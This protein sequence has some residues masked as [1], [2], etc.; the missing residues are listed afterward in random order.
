MKAIQYSQQGSFDHL[1]VVD[2]PKPQ[3]KSGD[4]LVRVTAATVTPMDAKLLLGHL[5]FPIPMPHIPGNGGAGYIED[6]GDTAFQVGQ[7][8]IL[9]GFYGMED[10]G[11]WREYM[12]VPAV[13]VLP[14]PEQATD[15]EGAGLIEAYLTAYTALV[16]SGNLQ[17]G[18]QVLV[19]AVGGGIG[20]AVVQLAKALGASQ[21][22]TTAGS[23]AKAE[24]ARQAGYEPVIDLSQ[25]PLKAGVRRI[26]DRQG[27]PLAIDSL[28]G[29]MTGQ[30]MEALGRDG[31]LVI[32]GSS[33][34][35][36]ISFDGLKFMMKGLKLFGATP[37]DLPAEKQHAAKQH[38]IQLLSEGKIRPLISKTFPMTAAAQALRYMSEDRPFGRVILTL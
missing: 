23:T 16:Y 21:V 4:V 36:E 34:G 7:R 19:P 14:L 1:Q 32:I 29:P 2:L 8:V 20:N 6:A 24:F 10:A 26:V 30:I 5:P 35:R 37:G 12:A 9:G 15:V 18:Q 25:E 22:I 27:V 38:I 31:T 13:D 28:G 11:T 33:A 17:A 3:L